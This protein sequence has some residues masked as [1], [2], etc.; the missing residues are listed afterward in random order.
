MRGIA[1]LINPAINLDVAG[2]LLC[3]GFFA[4]L[5]LGAIEHDRWLDVPADVHGAVRIELAFR[6]FGGGR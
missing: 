1:V 5:R 6:S 3:A 2:K 4:K